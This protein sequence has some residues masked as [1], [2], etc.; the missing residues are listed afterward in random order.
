MSLP[1]NV[2]PFLSIVLY[3]HTNVTVFNR[4]KDILVEP[5]SAPKR[6]VKTCKKTVNYKVTLRYFRASI[7]VLKKQ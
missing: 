2:T 1:G 7:A 6:L 3:K 5:N 4:R